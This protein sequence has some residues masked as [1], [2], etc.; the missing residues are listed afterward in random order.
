MKA[1]LDRANF[2]KDLSRM[3]NRE[4]ADE[5]KAVKNYN[6]SPFNRK[7]TDTARRMITAEIAKR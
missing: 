2:A 6:R 1:K 3:N 7:E 4:L 5:W